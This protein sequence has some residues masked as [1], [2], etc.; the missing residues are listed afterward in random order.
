MGSR[1][2][3]DIKFPLGGLNRRA[4]F[5]QQ[6]PYAT[7]DCLNVR[8]FDPIAGRERGGSRPGL[9]NSHVIDS[10]NP[11]R[12]LY[13]MDLS[14]GN[15]FVVAGDEFGGSGSVMSQA[16]TQASWAT[17]MPLVT[18]SALA[19]ISYAVSEGDAVYDSLDIDT[20]ES[21]SVEMFIAPTD[22]HNGSYRLYAR[23]ND[24]T[25]D[26]ETDGLE[27]EITFATDGSGDKA[28]WSHS[29]IAGVTTNELISDVSDTGSAAG[30]LSL[31]ITGDT[32]KYYWNGSY[33]G[34]NDIDTH[35]GLR[36]GMGMTCVKVGGIC[37]VDSFR[38]QFYSTTQ[39]TGSRSMLVCS[40]GGDLFR[41]TFSGLL[42]ILSS[43]MSLNADNPLTAAQS[44][45]E[46]VIADF[47]LVLSGI[48]NVTGSELV[49][50]D[51]LDWGA[52]E[53]S[54]Y[55]HVVVITNGTGT[56]TD[57]TYDIIVV[58]TDS[59]I[60][61][62]AIGTGTASY[63]IQRSPKVYDPAA[64]TLSIISATAGQVPSGNHLVTRFLDRIVFAGDPNAPH[65]WYMSRQGDFR[66]WDYSQT[67]AQRA[68]A[69]TAS[70]AGLPGAPITALIAHHDDYLIIACADSL[71]RMRGDPAYGG[72]LTLI[73]SK[74][75]CVG[76]N[77]W[78]IGPT[79][80][81]IFLSR[82]GIYMLAASGNSMPVPVSPEVLPREL[83]STDSK[84]S[85]ISLEYDHMG[86][87]VHVYV[88]PESFDGKL[89][90]WMDWARKTFWPVLFGTTLEP[91]ATTSLSSNSAEDSSVIL[92][93]RDGRIRKY[94]NMSQNDTGVEF[95]AYALMGPVPLGDDY[96]AGVLRELIGI[97][98]VGS[99]DVTWGVQ[100]AKYW[101]GSTTATAMA[102]GTWTAGLNPVV[103]SGGRGQALCV[104]VSSSGKW[105][106]DSIHAKR[107]LAGRSG[108]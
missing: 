10:T 11:I 41:E 8:P 46:L 50:T 45:Q 88:T 84:L 9:I 104:K 73:T 71:W 105:A 75:G 48:G 25:P 26:I 37:L 30:W 6:P 17:D 64:D 31:L 58:Y 74:V 15:G 57:G 77:A 51:V 94:H 39:K 20:S 2:K 106:V 96:N 72:T 79:G 80:E 32:I 86:R 54:I 27:V 99:E 16:W 67:D 18:E 100:V 21:Y 89:H 19:S 5:R 76:A 1:K 36:T 59:I 12:L 78:T 81:L 44:G 68:V 52:E 22:T 33:V 3:L 23:M 24:T 85:S 43:S 7:T 4:S 28:I 87:G 47:G 38:V 95:E 61:E 90:W 102:T 13:G 107:E 98:G 97:M 49:D 40:A 83:M 65:V 70:D 108:V 101:E 55:D 103:R 82:G 69:G 62:T 63:S 34:T 42:E 91:T 53:V 35:S 29:T 92:G 14:L 93:C 60:I 56:V 66:D